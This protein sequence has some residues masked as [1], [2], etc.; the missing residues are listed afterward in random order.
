M[1]KISKKRGFFK[2]L[3]LTSDY[4]YYYFIWF[5]FICFVLVSFLLGKCIKR[6][7]NVNNSFM[8]FIYGVIFILFCSLVLFIIFKLINFIL[9]IFYDIVFVKRWQYLPMS[10]E[11]M[12]KMNLTTFEE[13]LKYLNSQ[14][15]IYNKIIKERYYSDGNKKIILEIVKNLFILNE[16]TLDECLIE[17][18]CVNMYYQSET[19]IEYSL[20]KINVLI[21]K[22]NNLVT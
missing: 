1:N 10:I 12:K 2:T 22:N 19:D 17:Q 13:Y 14:F 11:E 5:K 20:A 15:C 18:V 6:L 9:E 16:I 21:N 3:S 7:M 4:Y 8:A